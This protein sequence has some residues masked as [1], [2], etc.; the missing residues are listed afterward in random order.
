MLTKEERLSEQIAKIQQMAKE[1]P[2]IDANALIATLFT[3]N[4][5][6]FLPEGEKMKAYLVSLFVP[7]FGLYFVAKFFTRTESDAR[8]TAW[9]CL[10]LTVVAVI[11]TWWVLGSAFSNPQIQQIQNLNPQD[12]QSLIE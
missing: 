12:I 7:P 3:K 6:S 8:R 9:V 10:L 11:L 1:N 4:Q 2:Q 5:E